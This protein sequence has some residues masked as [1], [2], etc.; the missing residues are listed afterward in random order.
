[1]HDIGK[2]FMAHTRMYLVGRQVAQFEPSAVRLTRAD[3]IK[4]VVGRTKAEE[5]GI[6]AR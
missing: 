1:M 4:T 6:L 2:G 5:G 3:R